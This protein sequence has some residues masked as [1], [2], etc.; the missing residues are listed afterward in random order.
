MD[1]F[2]YHLAQHRTPAPPPLT[3]DPPTTPASDPQDTLDLTPIRGS[4]G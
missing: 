4:H 2:Q 1:Q 3:L